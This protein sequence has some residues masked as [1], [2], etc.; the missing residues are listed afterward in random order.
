MIDNKLTCMQMSALHN[1]RTN[2]RSM[3]KHD[4]LFLSLRWL[5]SL[6]HYQTDF[7]S[8][9]SVWLRVFV[10]CLFIKNSNLSKLGKKMSR[11][12]NKTMESRDKTHPKPSKSNF[13]LFSIAKQ[14]S[15]LN[16][17]VYTL[18][19]MSFRGFLSQLNEKTIKKNVAPLKRILSNI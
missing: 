6:G 13:A 16:G 19:F 14:I 1:Q 10:S 11:N 5:T 17:V 15:R 8:F 3:P 9:Q 12:Y 18:I 4:M 2:G 7:K